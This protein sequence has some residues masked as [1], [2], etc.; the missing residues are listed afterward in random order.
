MPTQLSHP[1]Y[2][3]DLG[4]GLVLRWSTAADAE[5][6]AQ[7]YGF[8]FRGKPEDPG[9]IRRLRSTGTQLAC[10]VLRKTDRLSAAAMVSRRLV[11][12]GLVLFGLFLAAFAGSLYSRVSDLVTESNRP[13]R[14]AIVR[15]LVVDVT[16]VTAVAIFATA[17]AGW[18][19]YRH[20]RRL[21]RAAI[22][23]GTDRELALEVRDDAL[24]REREAREDAEHASRFKDDFLATVSHELRT[25]LNAIVGWAHVLKRGMLSGADRDRAIE[26]IDRNASSLTRI[27]N[28]LLDVSRLMQGR[29]NLSVAPLD[30][31][32]VARAAADTLAPASAARN[33]TVSLRL[34][35]EEVPIVADHGRIQQVA[36]HLLS[37][38]VKFTPPGG[39]INVEV[40]RIGSRA[41]LRVSDSGEGIDAG[42]A[43]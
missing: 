15:R 33:L 17:I 36:W 5:G 22:A 35:R 34:D 13:R 2:R 12:F 14:D 7:L 30:L 25:P 23:A 11:S 8:V 19:G 43:P 26:S 32:E 29:L 16:A 6:I 21:S 3:R 10:T 9:G 37:N 38:A 27:V 4:G 18:I 39:F 1:T 24:R 28:D 40:S 20:A 42:A 31:R 41:R